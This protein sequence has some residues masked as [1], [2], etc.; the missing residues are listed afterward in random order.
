MKKHFKTQQLITM[1][2][3]S[4]LFVN[5]SESEETTDTNVNVYCRFSNEE[6]VLP[7]TAGKGEIIVE[8]SRSQWE[9]TTDKSGFI[10]N[11]SRIQGGDTDLE[12]R[13]TKI[14]FSYSINSTTEERSQ[15]IYL[16]DINTGKQEKITIIQDVVT[17]KITID[18]NTK[19]QTVTG[20]G[21]MANVASWGVPA[22]TEQ[23]ITAMYG[24]S[25]LGYKILRIM[26]YPN[27]SQWNRDIAIAKKAQSLGAIIVVSPWTPPANLKSN[28]NTVGGY[29]LPANCD[30]YVDHLHSFIQ[31]MA[32]NGVR[33][34]AISLQNEPDI[35][36]EYDSCDWTPEQ[37]LNFIKNHA[38]KIG[39]NV[40]I[41]ASESFNFKHS[42]TDPL[43]NDA[44][45]VKNF[46]IVGGHIYGG[47]L[48]KY[49]SAQQKG[50]EVWMTEH[51]LNTEGANQD[52]LGWDAALIYAKEMHNCMLADFNAYIW[53]YLK[54]YYSMLGDGEK[55][56]TNG[57]ILKRGYV[58]SHYAN[59]ATG[60]QRVEA[61]VS[62]NPN[63]LV[64][65]YVSGEDIS[66]V[67]INNS[68]DII[69]KAEIMIPVPVT[70]CTG[71]V[72]TETD[73]IKNI[74]LNLDKQS[75][76]TSLL[77][78]SIVS[79]KFNLTH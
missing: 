56:T 49:S 62:G 3:L 72:T 79:I 31:Y 57:E 33:I 65:A 9:I 78:Q 40:K 36:V 55:G 1:L 6:I 5:C 11:F 54:R 48:A 42:Y 74:R 14:A 59:Y 24:E 2:A 71:I 58:L 60:H 39:D 23:N 12:N 26:V 53:W 8:W 29:L 16:T 67:I 41:I 15:D 27:N 75:A 38:R 50:K 13:F 30:K 17:I 44:L 76:T 19:Y 66:L 64:S 7:F 34:D 68:K 21:G 47:G 70:S 18:A 4:F 63:L 22:L 32:D 45:A 69:P 10:N 37:I 25:G 61:V 46:D 51:L 35:S 20:F 77:P 28:N 73:N 52:G 43:L